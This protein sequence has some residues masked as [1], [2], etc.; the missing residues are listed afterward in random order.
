MADNAAG[1]LTVDANGKKIAAPNT[2]RSSFTVPPKL[3]RASAGSKGPPARPET[4]DMIR[5]RRPMWGALALVLVTAAG[6][7]STG[8]V[9]KWSLPGYS[10][11]MSSML[12]IAM[13]PD[14]GNRRIME[15]AFV[16]E[17]DRHGVTATP[18]YTVWAD[19]LPD[20]QGVKDYVLANHLQGV[21]V[22]ARLPTREVTETTAGY[23][24][25]ETRLAYNSWAG[26]Y[27]TYYVEIEHEPT[28]RTE[29]VV[30]HRVDVWHSDG[31]G[32]EMVWT[33]ATESID[34]SSVTQ[35]GKEM[36]GLIVP[37]LVKDGIIPG[38]KK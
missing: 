22:A 8:L 6:C 25:R 17:L 30:P 19:A 20:T 28:T 32:G 1:V 11:P 15:D 9:N 31:K 7:A 5:L 16:R 33:V 35:V 4:P 10:T 2:K 27:Q 13:K 24:T 14:E 21:L 29:R 34:P 23:V 37:E 3:G 36:T 18:S 38:A 12:V 26:R